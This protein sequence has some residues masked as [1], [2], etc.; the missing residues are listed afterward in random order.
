VGETYRGNYA[1]PHLG[2]EVQE[3]RTLGKQ[4]YRGPPAPAPAA[5]RC[6][7]RITAR[8]VEQAIL[9]IEWIRERCLDRPEWEFPEGSCLALV[10]S[11]TTI[12]VFTASAPRRLL[13][14]G[15][16][17]ILLFE[18]LAHILVAAPGLSLQHLKT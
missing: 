9:H 12:R 7:L 14:A 1:S 16:R 3:S 8:Q 10:V 18:T 5:A 13:P 17:R 4:K 11:G 6:F 15:G 2:T